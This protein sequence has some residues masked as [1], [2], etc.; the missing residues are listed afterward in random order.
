M[1]KIEM[2]EWNLLTNRIFKGCGWLIT[3][4]GNNDENKNEW[5]CESK[6]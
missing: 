5:K 3:Y 4:Q 6:I 2:N 1:N